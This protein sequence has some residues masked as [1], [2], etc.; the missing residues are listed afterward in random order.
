VEAVIVCQRVSLTALGRAVR[1]TQQARHGIK[2]M[3]R[4]LSNPKL[5]GEQLYWYTVLARTLVRAETRVPVLL[6]WTQLHGEYWALQAAVPFEGRSVPIFAQAYHESKLGSPDVQFEFL[7]SLR[8]VL[9]PACRPVIVADGGFRSPFFA[10]CQRVGMDF[11]IRL[12][13]DRAVVDLPARRGEEPRA[14]FAQVFR[15]ARDY[16]R[17]LGK[18]R[19]FATSPDAGCYRLVLGSRPKKG[20]LRTRYRDDY[21]RKRA[22]EP[23]LLAT[24][25]ENDSA[26]T[27]VG[28][29]DARMQIEELFRD[30]KNA[31]FGWGLQF[32]G[33]R[34]PR[35][36][37]VLLL[38]V[39]LA[40]VAVILL[41]T[42]AAHRGLEPRFRASSRKQRVLSLF[43][44]GNLV[45][46]SA[47]LA[48]LR[49]G[50]VWKHLKTIRR[51]SRAFFPKL[52]SP[53]SENR[54]VPLPLP[55]GL[56]CVDCGWKGARYGWP[57]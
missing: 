33:S 7:R 34:C 52:R 15:R 44:L 29:Y 10:A 3:D 38:I 11:V 32:A 31:R 12:R 13:N 51:K 17:C 55:H 46:R 5:Q 19:P 54:S 27:I 28:F 8:Q 37:D 18:G 30:T 56:F 24:S 16:A 23:W 1:G 49:I 41:G 50:S 20:H 21:E 4:L 35:R 42:A 40:F 53:R 6:D 47:E 2:M 36:L 57:L 22:C 43:T 48:R 45:A 9:P 25:L 26:A 14:R 39:T